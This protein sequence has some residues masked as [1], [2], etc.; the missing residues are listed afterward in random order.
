MRTVVG[1]VVFLAWLPGAFVA[2]RVLPGAGGALWLTLAPFAGT[3]L[4]AS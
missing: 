2:E 4:L 3:V 1:V